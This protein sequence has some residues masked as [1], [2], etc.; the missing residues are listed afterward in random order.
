VFF[1]SDAGNPDTAAHFYADVEMFTN[2]SSGPDMTNYLAGWTTGQIAQQSNQWHGD[3]YHR[4]SNPQFDQLWQQYKVETDQSKRDQL[5]IQMND[6]LVNDVV[7]IPL[8]ART[9]PT[10]GKSKQIQG[11]KPNPWDTVLWNV[12]EWTKTGG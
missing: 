4:Y 6:I 12:A 8:V 5:A 3:N 7:V 2:G 10:D 9:Q 1:S 11:N